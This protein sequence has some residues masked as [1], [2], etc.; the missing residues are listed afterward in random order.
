MA[1]RRNSYD[2]LKPVVWLAIQLLT[3]AS[4]TAAAPADAPVTVSEQADTYTLA[5]GLVMA[6]IQKRSGV[7]SSLRYHGVELLASGQTG[8][9][10]GY[11]SS[12]GSGATGSR[13]AAA[14]RINPTDNGGQRVEISCRL[15]NDA[16]S[17][18]GSLDADYRYSLGRGESGLYVYAVL[19]HKPGY[20]G[21]SL[22]EARYCLKLNPDVFDY[23]TVD[24]DRRRLMP[25]GYDWD[26][27]APLNMKEARRMTTG[28]HQGEVEHKYDYAAVLADT[29]AYGWSGTRHQVGLW[30]VNPTIEYLGGGPTK[31]ELTGHLDVNPGGLPTLLN[32]WL[33]SHYGGTSLTV[34]GN[35][36]WVK[37]VGPFLLYC[38][39]GPDPATMWRNALAQANH[40]AG[41]WPYAWMKETHYPLA[42]NR[43]TVT[44]RL[45]LADP[46]APGLK[47]GNLWVGLTAPD[48]PATIDSPS[49][50]S[51]RNGLPPLVDW[52]RD[53]KFYQFWSRGD[54]DGRF[55]VKNIRPG[56]YTLHAIAEG[57]LGEFTLTNQVITN[58]PTLALGNLPW[59]PVRYGR[60]IWE[61][62]IPDRTAR[63]FRH[64][65][66]YWQW[67]L[68]FDYPKEFPHD[69]NFVLGQS[70]WRRDWNYVQP[71]HFEESETAPAGMDEASVA[72]QAAVESGTSR[73]KTRSTTWSIRFELSQAGRGQ[74]T[75]R[76]AFCGTHLGCH[77]EV[78]VNG[79][80][81]GDTGILPTTSAMQRDG[82]RAYWI[83]KPIAFDGR[84]LAAGSNTVQLV[85]HANNWSQG[86]MYDYLRLELNDS[87]AQ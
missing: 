33:G 48:Y 9:E 50:H 64:G 57:V 58:G 56:R 80:S 78:L 8:G 13:R 87:A 40:E 59:I 3:T 4:V 26:H 60:T 14:I 83:E 72:D 12:V 38:N 68:Y 6:S 47:M 27:G 44:G 23:L 73:R 69:V 63:E 46:G 39:S 18:S 10:G 29:P 51:N 25:S 54:P 1:T 21:F 5:N 17:P 28:V 55:M 22:G 34:G 82:I 65:D 61:I 43:G 53:A 16:A 41:A 36:S 52:Q 66:H 79:Q 32:M 11:W 67:G 24:A 45:N 70:D 71:P 30:L 84:L 20:P 37:V 81:V 42:A 76:L 74:A 19:E 62:G 86:V 85:S 31:V 49:P 35:E 75:L 2:W 77:V 15:F 7:L